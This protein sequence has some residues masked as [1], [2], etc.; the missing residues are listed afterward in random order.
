MDL[1]QLLLVGAVLALGTAGT[2][3]PGVPGRLL[4]WAAVL[5]WSLNERSTAAWAL[6][7]GATAVLLVAQVVI[8]LLPPRRLRGMGISRRMVVLAGAG[9]VLGFVLVPVVGAVP[10]F[11][12][13]IYVSERVRWGGH[14]Q[15][16]AA[17]RGL[18]RAAGTS[19]LVELLSCLLIT[20]AWLTALLTT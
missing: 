15:A 2:L 8:W 6:L 18:M 16:V 7:V 1:W 17:T 10:G 13:G 9:A 4:V 20:A 11:M 19:V 12:G 14:G 3:L 5:W